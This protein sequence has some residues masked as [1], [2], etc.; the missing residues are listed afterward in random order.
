[1]FYPFVCVCLCSS[2]RVVVCV[3]WWQLIIHEW[4]WF[5][6]MT[7]TTAV[8]TSTPAIFLWVKHQQT[9]DGLLF[10][11]IRVTLSSCTAQPS[12]NILNSHPESFDIMALSLTWSLYDFLLLLNIL[13]QSTNYCVCCQGYY[14][15]QEY[16]ATQGPLKH[17]IDDFWR[18]IWEQNVSVIVML[19]NLTERGRVRCLYCVML[20][21]CITLHWLNILGHFNFWLSLSLSDSL[22][23]TLSWTLKSGLRRKFNLTS[24]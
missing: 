10:H 11:T 3:C 20:Q 1:M 8:T 19:T 4:S 14:S 15:K 22:S 18:M 13:L 6:L 2:D 7:Q 21:V 23:E 12:L 16:I 24:V 5:L 17:T 9:F